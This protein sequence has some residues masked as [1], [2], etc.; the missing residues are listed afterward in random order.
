MTFRATECGWPDVTHSR[1]A[2]LAFLC[3]Y[4]GWYQTESRWYVGHV[5][6]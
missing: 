5:P 1:R 4:V 3:M 6:I 2:G